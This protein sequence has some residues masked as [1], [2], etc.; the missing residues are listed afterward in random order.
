LESLNNLSKQNIFIQD[1]GCNTIEKL[2]LIARSLKEKHDIKILIID[3]L[4]LLS[5]GQK[6]DSRQYEVAG[7]SLKLKPLARE[8]NIP[9]IAISQLSRKVEERSD[10]RPL[11][12]DLRDSG[13]IEQDADAIVFVNRPSYYNPHEKP[14]QAEIIVAKN[15]NGNQANVWLNFN[16]GCG[17][18]TT[19]TALPKKSQT[20][21]I[22]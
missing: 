20:Q 15:R 16:Q 21:G 10:K 12:S 6:S 17:K 13:Q 3:Y 19:Q 18:F 4:Q 8:L 5:S 1:E 2:V 14:G 9:I 7:I 22:L 11:L